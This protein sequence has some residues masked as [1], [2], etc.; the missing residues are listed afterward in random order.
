MMTLEIE[1]GK[2]EICRPSLAFTF[3]LWLILLAISSSWTL[4]PYT[5][6]V[7]GWGLRRSWEERT[8]TGH[9]AFPRTSSRR[10]D[11]SGLWYR[12]H[13]SP[14][15]LR[16]LA[17][18]HTAPYSLVAPGLLTTHKGRKNEG[19]ETL[20]IADNVRLMLLTTSCGIMFLYASFPSFPF[21]MHFSVF[22]DERHPL[23]THIHKLFCLLT[24]FSLYHSPHW[25]LGRLELGMTG[26][27]TFL[28]LFHTVFTLMGNNSKETVN[29]NKHNSLN[30]NWLI[31]SAVYQWSVGEVPKP[32]TLLETKL[33]P[34][35][36]L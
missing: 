9:S 31:Y 19:D 21:C 22:W 3:L 6:V 35:S 30:Q 36:T 10:S 29:R 28:L 11:W 1:V 16:F 8:L 4:L 32:K 12:P 15:L 34:P 17:Q 26:H 18:S 2:N 24:I 13:G 23:A 20:E 27:Y 33:H 14:A 25:L 7:M 5:N